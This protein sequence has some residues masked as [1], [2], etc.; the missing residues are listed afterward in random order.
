MRSRAWSVVA[1]TGLGILVVVAI[2][3]MMTPDAS[4]QAAVPAAAAGEVTKAIAMIHPLGNS[5]VEGKVV[6]T[7]VDGGLK[8]EAELTGLTPGEHGFHVHEFGDCSMADGKCA[9]G[10][11][12]PDKKPHAGPDAPE[13]HVG[14][15][16]NI[17]ADSDGKAT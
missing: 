7:K 4:G 5:K 17:K 2:A 12:N 11:F 1:A 13:R 9:G 14:D 10:H 6:F 15:F 16:G 3:H 8:I